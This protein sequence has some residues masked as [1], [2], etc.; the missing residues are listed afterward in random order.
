MKHQA[1]TGNLLMASTGVTTGIIY[2]L[3]SVSIAPG[4]DIFSKLSGQHVPATEVAFS[5]F[6]IQILLMLPFVIARGTLKRQTRQIMALHA[7]RGF[8]MAVGMTSFAIALQAMNVADAIAIFFVEPAI[9]TVLSGVFLKETIGW[10]RY[11]AC[12]VGFIGAL[13]IIQPNF[14]AAGWIALLPM[15]SALCIAIFLMISKRQS[16]FEDPWSMQLQAGLWGA[17][18]AFLA[19]VLVALAGFEQFAPKMPAGIVWFYLFGTGFMA[20]LSSLLGVYALRHAPAA[21][22]AP[23]QYLE[24]V[25]A[26]LF[27]WIIFGDVLDA[28]KWFGVAIIIASGLFIILR[29]QRLKSAT[30][31]TGV[32]TAP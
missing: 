30:R 28:W 19:M 11:L 31:N 10:R 17:L 13:F 22:L 21:T 27:T 12:L 2:M 32:T 20:T 4:I 7:A 25:S 16:G 23:L 3:L 14:Q 1:K 6:I 18:F 29:E 26:T 8:L 24:I 9:L 5:R 15:L